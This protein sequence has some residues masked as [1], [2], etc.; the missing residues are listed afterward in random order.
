MASMNEEGNPWANREIARRCHVSEFMVRQF[1][2]NHTAIKSQIETGK[3]TFIHPKTGKSTVMKMGN[4]GKNKN[5]RGE[6][7]RHGKLKPSVAKLGHS[8]PN[9]MI[10]VNLPPKNPKAAAAGIAALFSKEFIQQF[11]VELSVYVNENT[12]LTGEQA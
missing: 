12:T 9:P 11:I 10:Q 5:R 4:I 6:P 8:L 2:E 7:P 3:R 1:R